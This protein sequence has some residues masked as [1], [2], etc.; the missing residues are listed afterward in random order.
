MNGGNPENIRKWAQA[1]TFQTLADKVER[2]EAIE[3]IRRGLEEAQAGKGR[4]IRQAIEA[5]RRK[6]RIPHPS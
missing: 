5:I 4:S 2:A 6:H 3:G 1:E